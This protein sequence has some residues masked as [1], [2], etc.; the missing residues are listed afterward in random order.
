MQSLYSRGLPLFLELTLYNYY[1]S[2]LLFSIFS[3]FAVEK[4][5]QQCVEFLR[6]PQKAFD[7]A[8]KKHNETKVSQL[9]QL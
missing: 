2:K 3:D 5:H 7:T 6:N 8:R 1:G 9:A 4:G